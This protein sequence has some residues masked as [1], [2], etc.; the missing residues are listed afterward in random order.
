MKVELPHPT[1]SLIVFVTDGASH[2]NHYNMKSYTYPLGVRYLSSMGLCI[3]DRGFSL[4]YFFS[5]N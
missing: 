1:K 4:L 5:Q 3:I 2:N